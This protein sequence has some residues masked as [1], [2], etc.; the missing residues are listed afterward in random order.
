MRDPTRFCI[1]FPFLILILSHQTFP[2]F[3]N[4]KENIRF[5]HLTKEDGLSD[6]FDWCILQDSKG[7]VWVGTS[8]GLDRYDGR[9]FKIFKYLPENVNSLGANTIRALYEDKSGILWVGTE[10]GGLN[11]YNSA[12][13][14]FTRFTYD[15]NNPTSL[16][17]NVVTSIYEDKS[18]A[19]W[20]GTR[21]GGLNLFNRENEQFICYKNNPKDPTSLSSN[22][23]APMYEDSNGNLWIG[24]VGGGLNKFDRIN[25][26]FIRYTNN[27]SDPTSLSQND[28]SGISE[29]NFGNIWVSTLGGGLNKFN[30]RD[31]QRS[32]KFIHYKNN[33]NDPHSLNN[34]NIATLFI[35]NN[36]IMWVGTWGGGL[37]KTVLRSSSNSSLSFISYKHSNEDQY[38]LNDDNISC[39]YEDPSGLLWIG[40]WGGGLHIYNTQQ[41]LFRHYTHKT[42]DPSTLSAKGVSAVYEDRNGTL[43][44]GTWDGGLNKMD[45]TTNKFIHYQHNPDDRTSLSSNAVSAIYEDSFG[46]LWIGTWQGGLNKFDREK[47]KFYKYQYDHLNPASISDDRIVTICEDS[48][49]GL[50]I[51]TYYGGLNKF[52]RQ[53]EKFIHYKH[54]DDDSTSLSDNS[55]SVIYGDREGVLWIGTRFGGLDELDFRN[56]KF[57]HY[58]FNPKNSKNVNPNKIISI[59]EDGL[60]I[61]WIGTQEF[62]LIK[63]NKETGQFKNY[64]MKDGLP[65]D[66]ILGILE[67]NNGNLWISNNPGLSKFNTLTEK[68]RNYN[69]EDGLQSNEFEEYPA[70]YKSKTGELIF[71]GINGFNIFYPD[72]IK[73]NPHIPP[74]Y[75]TDFY[76]FN[77]SVPIGFDSLSNR[78]ILNKSIIECEEIELNFDDNVFSFE[79]AALDLHSPDKNQYA[80]ILE[81]F[82][83]KWIF[84]D[85]NKR[86]A[87]YTNLDPGEYTFRV[88]GSNNDGVWNEAGTSLK[89]IIL[90]PW[91]K[92]W[93]AYSLYVI[94]IL[95]IL[96]ISTRFYLNRQKLK[97]KLVL[98]SEHAEKLEEIAKMKSDFFANISHE[99]RTPLTLILGPAENIENKLSAN[100]IKDAGIISRNAR[101]LLQ[102]VNQLLDLAKLDSGKLKLEASPGNI[103]SFI[104]GI[105][106]SFESLS[107]SK[108]VMLKIKSE[109]EFIEVYFDKEKMFKVFSN[110]LSNAFKFTPERGNVFLTVNETSNNTVEI[111]IRNTGVAIPQKELPKLFDRFYQVD[112]SQTKEYEGTGI[113]LA[114]VKELIELH[115]GSILVNSEDGE[116]SKKDSAWTEFTINF[117]LGRDHL[118]ED[119]IPSIEKEIV[120]KEIPVDEAEYVSP[121]SL[122]ET[123]T[124]QDETKTTILVVEDNYDMR[125]YIKESLSEKYTIEEAVNGE[126]GVRV[127]QTIIPDLIISDLMMPKMDGNELAR[128][129]KNDERTS[130]IPIIILTAKSGQ[131]N[132]I[133]GLLTGAD[134]YLTKPFDL[135][136]LRVRVEN[137]INIRK[138][139]QE[140]FSKGDF[141]MKR[142]DKKL[143]S[144]DEKFLSKV[145]EVIEKHISEEEFTIE[146]CSNEVGLSRTHFHKKLRALVGKSPSQYVRTVRLYRAKQMIEEEKGN[147]SEV[148]YSV[149][150]SSP[151]YFSKCFKEEFGYPPRN[152][153]V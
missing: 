136:E 148:A 43:W 13:E 92:T 16:S 138:K 115:Q 99:F 10:G 129:L 66:Y 141:L 82:N 47:E 57:R 123:E 52:E 105:A 142:S 56:G 96:I 80:Y 145:L 86:S 94:F 116:A 23:I 149:G 134:D 50:W 95:S 122:V 151:A 146:G 103:I 133:E 35:D 65:G 69:I 77:Q 108:D 21:E 6:S 152:L 33:P 28:I 121:K 48:D 18:G 128:I 71:G 143:K 137:L 15:P 63:L 62:G 90:P 153:S 124:I 42:D 46:I 73:D 83:K 67:D 132:K 59:Y 127:A 11:R 118:K 4:P 140:K 126:Q 100:P 25:K 119:E 51:G 1:L 135:K 72:S 75:I 41:K 107:E 5:N 49:G 37:N 14:N 27:P 31:D 9:N 39:I 85:A 19:L 40:T 139:L 114:L 104:K 76:L 58:N 120:Q 12:Q 101:R 34:N 87:T 112:S 8:D 150:F 29:D 98:E 79:F 17:S 97:Q 147:V 32:V 7:F 30:Y 78:T 81:G 106:L 38:S 22:T 20:I 131:E 61:L 88:K 2:Q 68:F 44:I 54:S 74:I 93:W 64:M 144:I 113:G 117:P 89:I 55:V 110:L 45:R 102:L 36:N 111:R 130:H 24:T 109:K 53:S 26:K 84:T 3:Y 60:G 125:E 91:W 70:C